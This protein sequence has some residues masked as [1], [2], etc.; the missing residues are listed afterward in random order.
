MVGYDPGMERISIGNGGW[1]RYVTS[2]E[3]RPPVFVRVRD[4]DGRLVVVELYVE[5]D[6]GIDG[7]LLRW[8]PLG[9]IEAWVNSPDTA[10]RVR[11]RLNLPG[12]DLSRAAGHYGTSFGTADHWVAQ[13]L[14]A[15]VKDSGVD[16]APRAKAPHRPRQEEPIDLHLEVPGDRRGYG[17]DFYRRVAAVYGAASQRSRG[18]A[19][20][21]A[22][23]NGVPVSTVHRWVKEARRRGFLGA[24]RAG[25]AG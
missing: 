16:Q 24:G 14:H 1:A 17:D 7:E 23:A 6:E 5:R 13:M 10:D 21:I 15:Q 22:D 8:L 11:R 3:A 25:K 2:D 4:Q 19:Q 20:M 9:R 12:P 18:P